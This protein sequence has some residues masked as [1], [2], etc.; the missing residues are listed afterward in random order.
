MVIEPTFSVLQDISLWSL[1]VAVWS[2]LLVT[3]HDVRLPRERIHYNFTFTDDA[4]GDFCVGCVEDPYSIQCVK[5]V[6]K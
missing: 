4:T 5:V 1:F 6:R 3:V 2:S